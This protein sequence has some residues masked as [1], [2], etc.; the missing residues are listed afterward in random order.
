MCVCMF[1]SKH[2]LFA[3][4]LEMLVNCVDKYTKLK[5]EAC[6]GKW[7]HKKTKHKNLKKGHRDFSIY[8]GLHDGAVAV[9]LLLSLTDLSLLSEKMT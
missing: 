9:I 4:Y 6:L 5:K 1:R 2:E 8:I 7:E 3:Q